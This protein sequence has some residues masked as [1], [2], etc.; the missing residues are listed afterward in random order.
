MKYR[1]T[2]CLVGT[3]TMLASC[4]LS[5]GEG[6]DPD[7][8]ERP[9]NIVYILADD[10]G[11]GDLGCYGQQK[12]ETPHIDRLAKSGMKFT[13]HY[14]G[15]TVCAPSRCALMTG[16][17]TGHAQVRG[18]REV[19]PEGQAPMADGTVIIPTLL[20]QAG[21][22][23][24]MF[25]KWGL[26]APGSTSDPANFF[27]EVYGYNCQ[28]E[29]HDFY[30]RHLWHNRQKIPLDGETYSHDLI[31]DQALKFIRTNK[32]RP[33]FCYMPITIP[34]AAMQAPPALHEK[35]RQRFP[36]FENKVGKYA[37]KEVPNP[38]AAFPAM[39]EHLDQGVGQVLA[40]LKELGIAENTLVIFTSDNGPHREGGHDPNFWDSNGPLRGIKRDLYEGGIRAPM[41]A[42]WPREIK[43]GS[44][45]DHISAFWD[46]LPT[47]CQMAGVEAPQGLDGISMMPTFRGEQQ[48][49]HDY[50]YWEFGP[51][52][53][54]Q[55]IRQGNFK[56]VRGNLRK[57]P[58]API[59]LYDLSRDLGEKSNVAADYPGKVAEMEIL[60]D[61]AR[62]VSPSFQLFSNEPGEK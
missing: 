20:K 25:G 40:L 53:G 37:G 62:E 10:L 61:Q 31:M 45:S 48:P 41:I 55:A 36:Q 12:F 1:W 44:T 14:S 7:G 30:P 57:N 54:W 13:Q 21:Y 2:G 6:G 23:S 60:F 34:H 3:L 38:V 56:A 58:D 5:A 52:G 51:R 19:K 49:A 16:L 11:Y 26:G 47:F 4:W 15:S 9:P 27:D 43:A 17:H 28:R 29:A 22:V 35:Y 46:M 59:E 50:L 39:V 8:A 32:D 24:G 33:F 18:N 42:C